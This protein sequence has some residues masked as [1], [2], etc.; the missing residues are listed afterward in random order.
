MRNPNNVVKKSC[1]YQKYF[2][3]GQTQINHSLLKGGQ[4]GKMDSKG[5]CFPAST[6]YW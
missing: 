4:S 5:A 6:L 1:K 3:Y 2:V